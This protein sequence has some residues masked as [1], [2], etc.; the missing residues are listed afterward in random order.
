MTR[1]LHVDDKISGF[2]EDFQRTDPI[3]EELR[4]LFGRVGVICFCNTLFNAT[5]H[6]KADYGD[7]LH[8]CTHF[9]GV[10]VPQLNG[11][12]CAHLLVP[13][14]EMLGQGGATMVQF[15]VGW[16]SHFTSIYPTHETTETP[17]TLED[18]TDVGSKF[19]MGMQQIY[20]NSMVKNKRM[21][22]KTRRAKYK[23]SDKHNSTEDYAFVKCT[24]STNVSMEK[25][26]LDVLCLYKF[27]D[28][29]NENHHQHQTYAKQ[30]FGQIKR[31]VYTIMDWT[32][33]S[34]K[35]WLLCI[36]FVAML[37]NCMSVESLQTKM[38]TE[39]LFREMPDVLQVSK[40]LSS[41]PEV[42]CWVGTADMKGEVLNH[43]GVIERNGEV[44]TRSDVILYGVDPNLQATEQATNASKAENQ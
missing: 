1:I 26:M 24:P 31:Q 16:A 43:L 6:F 10:H 3:Y 32:G 20:T 9:P 21:T 28:F 19:L 12:A 36:L 15:Y 29:M 42:R 11:T 27:G 44:F 39:V 33:T 14:D 25:P 4:P 35:Y 2:K 8:F 17:S 18:S 41:S 30:R 38:P 37:L 23:T 22:V 7:V 40:C 34:A 13:A 5:Q